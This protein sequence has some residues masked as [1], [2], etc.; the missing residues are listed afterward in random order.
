[1]LNYQSYPQFNTVDQIKTLASS[2][3]KNVNWRTIKETLSQQTKDPEGTYVWWYSR[4]SK[5]NKVFHETNS[6]CLLEDNEYAAGSGHL[7]IEIKHSDIPELNIFNKLL[8]KL[9]GVTYSGV[10]FIGPNSEIEEHTDRNMYNVLIVVKAP[11]D[12]SLT[13]DNKQFLLK[14]NEIFAFDGDLKHSALN[15]TDEDWVLFALR[16]NKKEFQI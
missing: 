1:M 8:S 15:S 13:I 5:D 7:N 14:E 4:T 12:V 11:T 6:G 10:F 16:I 3:L 9:V 2:H